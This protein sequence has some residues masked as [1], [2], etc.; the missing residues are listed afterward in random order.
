M[1]QDGWIKMVTKQNRLDLVMQWHR[2]DCRLFCSEALSTFTCP[3]TRTEVPI[4]SRYPVQCTCKL[5][6]SI[7]YH[8][9]WWFWLFPPF[10]SRHILAS[11]HF[12]E[13][14][15]REAQAGK[16]GK[17]N[18]KVSYPEFTLGEDGMVSTLIYFI[19]FEFCSLST[20]FEVTFDQYLREYTNIMKP[21]Y[22]N[23]VEQGCR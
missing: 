21:F 6:R 22:G 3:Q 5:V 20:Q 18:Y 9:T 13:N 1:S 7:S 19:R 12:N 8:P 2:F 23:H 4:S 10:P 14:V 17:S 16:N 11:L 15:Q